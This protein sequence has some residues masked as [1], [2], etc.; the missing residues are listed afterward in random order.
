MV[1]MSVNMPQPEAGACVIGIDFGTLSGRALVVRVRDGAE[2]GT[3]VHEYRHGVMG[4][5]LAAT[6]EPLPPGWALQDPEADRDRLRQRALG[7]RGALARRGYA[8]GLEALDRVARGEPLEPGM[9]FTIEPMINA[10]KKDIHLLA[11]GWSVATKDHSLSAQWAHTI[12]VTETGWE[13]LTLS[14]GTPP[15]PIFVRAA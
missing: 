3:A 15:P 6:G 4:D 1:I 9:I 5:V 7:P 12:L 11:D 14:A 8:A 2:L 13:V 10:G